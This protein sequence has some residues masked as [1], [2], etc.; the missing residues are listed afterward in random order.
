[1]ADTQLTCQGCGKQFK[2]REELQKHEKDCAAL[3]QVQ[4]GQKEAAQRQ[5]GGMGQSSKTSQTENQPP[6]TRTAGGGEDVEE[7][8]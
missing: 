6:K 4:P 7:S 1:M 8:E 2:T 3:K 5:S